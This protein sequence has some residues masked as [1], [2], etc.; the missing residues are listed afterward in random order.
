[1]PAT[2]RIKK[3]LVRQLNLTYMKPPLQSACTVLNQAAR[4]LFTLDRFLFCPLLSRTLPCCLSWC[5]CLDIEQLVRISSLILPFLLVGS[6]LPRGEKRGIG[7]TSRFPVASRREAGRNAPVRVGERPT[8]G[9]GS[10]RTAQKIATIHVKF[11]F[12]REIPVRAAHVL[13]PRLAN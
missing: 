10:F 2:R 13:K 3:L 4:P 1:V 6:T 5:L 8:N 12:I 7:R 9:G 11:K